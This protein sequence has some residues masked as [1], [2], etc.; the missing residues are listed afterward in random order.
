MAFVF[1][2]PLMVSEMRT[3]KAGAVIDWDQ[4]KAD[5]LL[6]IFFLANVFIQNY[7]EAS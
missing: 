2:M 5:L 6:Q 7:C 3:L 1:E 4:Q